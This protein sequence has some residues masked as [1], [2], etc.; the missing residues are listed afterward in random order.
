M[1]VLLQQQRDIS[2][3]PSLHS[4]RIGRSAECHIALAADVIAAGP[5]IIPG[6]YHDPVVVRHFG[7][8]VLVSICVWSTCTSS[9]PAISLHFPVLELG[10]LS[11]G[12]SLVVPEI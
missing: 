9:V 6:I 12:G 4:D 10:Y 8:A 2:A 1:L 11:I 7:F 5:I 3:V